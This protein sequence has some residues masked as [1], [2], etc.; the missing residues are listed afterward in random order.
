M[1]PKEKK[2][3]KKKKEHQ[4]VSVNLD[5]CRLCDSNL[6]CSGDLGNMLVAKSEAPYKKSTVTISQNQL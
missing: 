6:L 1:T 5:F 4:T 2:I 3:K